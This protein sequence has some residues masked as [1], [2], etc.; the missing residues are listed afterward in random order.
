MVQSLSLELRFLPQV[1]EDG[2]FFEGDSQ[3]PEVSTLLLC[4]RPWK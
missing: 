2:G 3:R 4:V 1:A